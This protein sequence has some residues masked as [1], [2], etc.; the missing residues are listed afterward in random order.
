[1]SRLG[2]KGAV[3]GGIYV[4][5]DISVSDGLVDQVGLP[6]GKRGLAVPGF[7]DL[8]VNGFGGVD[9][10]SSTAEEW[11]QAQ[12]VLASTGVTSYV[13]NVI[14]TSATA[15]SAVL[16][17]SKHVKETS[18]GPG[19]ALL[20]LHLEGPFLSPEKA[21]IHPQHFLATPSRDSLSSWLTSGPVVMATLA[22]ELPGALAEIE[23]LTQ[24]GII[25]SLGH[26]N[27]SPGEASA[28]FDAGATTV[29]HLFNGMSGITARN[30]GLAGVALSREGVTLQLILDF[31]HVDKALAELVL[32]FAPHRVALVTDCLPATGTTATHF[33]LGETEIGI[34]E[35]K[36]V[37]A[38]GVLAGS[39]L[40]M[41]QALRNAIACGMNDVDA[42]NATSLN[43]L[44]VLDPT[45]ASL[46]AEGASADIVVLDDSWAIDSVLVGGTDIVVSE[47][48]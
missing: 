46:L 42:I 14:S 7:V 20:G 17:E 9:F 19:A 34:R 11:A 5:G 24:Q 48:S 28:G 4:A 1:M 27:S 3:V 16:T 25:V 39:L 32:K 37:N 31:L 12:T 30:P 29:T 33:T 22:P 10:S 26:S 13:A 44:K 23:W 45:T 41:D 35:G 2:V 47:A 36:A 15:M 8:Q 38:D 6:P 40:T 18:P 21:G 43:P